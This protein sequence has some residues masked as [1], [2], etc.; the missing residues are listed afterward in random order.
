MPGSR[1]TAVLTLVA[2]CV[3]ATASGQ[4]GFAISGVVVERGSNRPL[5]HVLVSITPTEHRDVQLS[6]V[7]D[8]SGRFAFANVPAAKYSLVAQKRGEPP[9]G[10]HQDEEYA[11]AIAVGPGLDSESIVFPLDTPGSLSGTVLDDQ[12]DPVAQAQVWLFD[13]GVSSGRSQI[14]PAGTYMTGSSGNFYIGHLSPGMYYVAVQGRPWYAQNFFQPQPVQDQNYA[15]EGAGAEPGRSISELDVAYP[16][17][18]YGD[19]SDPAS[20]SPITISEGGS[21]T[22]QITMRP[23]PRLS[24]DVFHIRTRRLPDSG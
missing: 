3:C 11:T 13:K 7:T 22:V 23:K 10:Y 24:G 14:L 20:A 17:T 19:T 2:G 5:K 6:C 1:W 12:G 4:T 18:Y 16:V 21:A 8:G 9:E 15:Q